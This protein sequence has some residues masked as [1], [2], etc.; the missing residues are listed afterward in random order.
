[1]PRMYA[2]GYLLLGLVKIVNSIFFGLTLIIFVHILLTWFAPHLRHPFVRS[3]HMLASLL[4]RPLKNRIPLIAG[5][6]F[7]AVIFLLILMFL[8][9]SFLGALEHFAQG[10]I[11]S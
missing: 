9:I 3:I 7:S 8:D 6:D 5:I 4:L 2:L 10:L 11:R 1:M